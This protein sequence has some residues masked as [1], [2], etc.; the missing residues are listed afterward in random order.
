M[1]W[2]ATQECH[3]ADVHMLPGQL[4]GLTEELEKKYKLGKFA[5][6]I[7]DAKELRRDPSSKKKIK[8]GFQHLK[9]VKKGEIGDM[10]GEEVEEGMILYP[11]PTPR[12]GEKNYQPIPLGR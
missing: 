1:I 4:I 9:A 11:P 10:E 8:I 12:R 6:E 3:I 7:P 2:K 5:E